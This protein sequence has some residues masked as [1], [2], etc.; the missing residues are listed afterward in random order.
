[1]IALRIKFLKKYLN[2]YKWATINIAI[3]SILVTIIGI[4]WP[5]IFKL[6]VDEVFINKSI[7]V[8]WY[9]I[10]LYLTMFLF[11]KFIQFLWRLSDGVLSTE[12]LDDIRQDIFKKIFALK[13]IEKDNISSGQVVDILNND[14]KKVYE[15]IVSEGI[16]TFTSFLRFLISIVYICIFNLKVGLVIILLIPSTYLLSNFFKNRFKVY[17]SKL[18]L[19]EQNYNIWLLDILSG[20]REIKYLSSTFYVRKKFFLKLKRMCFLDIKQEVESTHNNNSQQMLNYLSDIIIF[21]IIGYAILYES[22][23]IGEFVAV[24][25]YYG[26]SKYFFKNVISFFINKETMFLSIDRIINLLDLKEE[27]TGDG[28]FENGDIELKNIHFAYDRNK[29]LEGLNLTIKRGTSTAIVGRSGSGKS[30]IG[31]LLLKFYEPNEGSILINNKNIN[32]INTNCLRK[33][34]AIVRQ[35][36]TLFYGKSIRENL[37]VVNNLASDEE[38]WK[39][40]RL[41]KAEEFVKQLPRQL[42][43]VI[44]L[45]N[46]LSSGQIQRIM[47]ARTFLK[48]SEI[49]IFDESTSNL[50]LETEVEI[51][52][53][54]KENTSGKTLIIIAYR[55]NALKDVENI[56]FL[57]K[58]K[59][60]ESGTHS[61]LYENCD[62]YSNLID[63]GAEKEK[64]YS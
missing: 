42:D 17:A 26:W 9:I 15:L 29:I 16:L 3:S 43:E 48:N 59:V 39:V 30:T 6:I 5:L 46:D 53:S 35:E 49:I 50:D 55:V 56:H 45:N 58:G 61:Y 34:I 63:G 21:S 24:N 8:L 54:L 41:A 40:L 38:I 19:E 52:E 27:S 18:K 44:D 51:L 32:D 20:L 62:L 23:T 31:S 60:I 2:D 25:I 33:S 14:T 11:E 13:S 36:Q 10:G 37:E 28:E 12:F 7:D 57:D 1:M 47:L 4:H 64:V 22:M